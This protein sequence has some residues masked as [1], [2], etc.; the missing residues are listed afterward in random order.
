MQTEGLDTGSTTEIGCYYFFMGYTDKYSAY[1]IEWSFNF[2]CFISSTDFLPSL[3][4]LNTHQ[5]NISKI[6]T[7][8]KAIDD[9]DRFIYHHYIE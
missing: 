1:Q 7:A 9:W 5:V 2:S 3:S 4:V 8:N 6:K